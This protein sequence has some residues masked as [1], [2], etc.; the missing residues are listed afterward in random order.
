MF[1]PA[2]LSDSSGLWSQWVHEAEGGQDWLHNS[3]KSWGDLLS[4]ARGLGSFS[5]LISLVDKVHHVTSY[6][7]QTCFCLAACG[8][9]LPAEIPRWSPSGSS[10]LRRDVPDPGTPGAW[11]ARCSKVMHFNKA[12]PIPFLKGIDYVLLKW[13]LNSADPVPVGHFRA[14]FSAWTTLHTCWQTQLQMLLRE[15][16][17]RA[18]N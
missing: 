11:L 5:L 14:F 15:T 8:L 10:S 18:Q 9:V 3:P 12:P 16:C 6:F 2:P 13:A 1:I 4:L 17:I 7:S